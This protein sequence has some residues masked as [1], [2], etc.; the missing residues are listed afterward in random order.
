M[1]PN[2]YTI[3]IDT[4]KDIKNEYFT[5]SAAD[6]NSH[7][8]DIEV[9]QNGAKYDLTD[10]TLEIDFAKSDGKLNRQTVT[11]DDAVEGKGTCTLGT[12]SIN[13]EGGIRAEVLISKELDLLTTKRFEFYVTNPLAAASVIESTTEL[14][15]LYELL[16]RV[17]D[18]LLRQIEMVQ[19]EV[20]REVSEGLRII[21]HNELLSLQTI[22]EDLKLT[23][24]N[25]NA[26][27][28]SNE[29]IRTINEI[30]RVERDALRENL[31]NVLITLR[32]EL[33]DLG[34]NLIDIRNDAIIATNNANTATNNANSA[35]TNANNVSDAIAL[36]EGVR[37]AA[38]KAR[39]TADDLRATTFAGYETRISNF[40]AIDV[41]IRNQDLDGYIEGTIP[42]DAELLG[43][44]KKSYFATKEEV[45]NQ[46]KEIIE[47][48]NRIDGKDLSDENYTLE[49]KNKLLNIEEN[50]KDDQ[51]ANEVPYDN[52]ISKLQATD[53]QA[54]LDELK[55]ISENLENNM[56]TRNNDLPTMTVLD[57]EI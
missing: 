18:L 24:I 28:E 20:D 30:D 11:I 50:A 27:A 43:G 14:P 41:I 5:V 31:Y 16:T 40:E 48:V 38:E 8:L 3:K 6:I 44:E 42:L 35:A 34:N 33:L 4:M 46:A 52:I 49:E 32:N 45:T 55:A 10:L 19:N 7:V 22:L 13:C 12:N 57:I 37:V 1:N 53:V 9:T 25:T 15:V 39:V 2:I 23:L 36:T 54:A 47:K 26:Y 51:L 56:I 29:G 17:D 21:L